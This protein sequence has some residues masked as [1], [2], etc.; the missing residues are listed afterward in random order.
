MKQN[1]FVVAIVLTSL[2]SPA[3]SSAQQCADSSVNLGKIDSNWLYQNPSTKISFQLPP[4]WYFFDALAPQ[5]KYVRIGSDFTKLSAPIADNGPGPIV[6][7]DQIKAQPLDF[8]LTLFSVAQLSDTVPIVPVANESQQNRT[9]SCK[10]YYAEVNDADTLL[11]VLYQKYTRSK[12]LPQVKEGKL[13]ELEYKYFLLAVAGKSG[14]VENRIYGA[15]NFG[16]FNVLVRITYNTPADL[17]A[18]N[19]ACKGLTLQP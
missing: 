16:C 2:F 1:C 14:A 11:K 13:G 10:A 18:I 3:L 8:A 9:V 5:K 17:A 19:D 15:K 4:S 12:E 7:L 6:A